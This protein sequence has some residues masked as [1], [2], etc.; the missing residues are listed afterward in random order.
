MRNQPN[1]CSRSPQQQ[2]VELSFGRV[3][4]E[5]REGPEDERHGELEEGDRNWRQE[6]TEELQGTVVLDLVVSQQLK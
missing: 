3:L 2:E 1:N 6:R 4:L 5:F